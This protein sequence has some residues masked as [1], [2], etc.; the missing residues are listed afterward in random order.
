MSDESESTCSKYPNRCNFEANFCEW[1]NSELNEF[2][3][4]RISGEYAV[5]DI[6][7]RRDHTTNTDVGSY[8]YVE[9]KDRPARKKSTL[10]GPSFEVQTSS[11]CEIRFY[12][13][14]YG[15]S[16]GRLSVSIRTAYGGGYIEKWTKI[17]SVG[18]YWEKAEIRISTGFLREKTYQVIIEAELGNSTKKRA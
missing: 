5:S 7:P 13:Y 6:L 1:T 4:K 3:W 18:Q 14:M 15:N 9:T 8:I 2:N 12:Y 16:V 17:G 11:Q 10:F